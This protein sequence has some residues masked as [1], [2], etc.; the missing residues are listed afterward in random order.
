[1]LHREGR[2][3]V[4]AIHEH[5]GVFDVIVVDGAAFRYDCSVEAITKLAS[6]GM[7]ILDDSEALPNTARALR[8]AGLIQVDFAG[9]AAFEPRVQTTSLLLHPKFEF[10]PIG[11]TQPHR[12]VGGVG[13]RVVSADYPDNVLPTNA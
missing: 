10:A 7:I 2:A 6:G 13:R 12:I 5:A 9:F 3:F 1:M 4:D 8:A 11:G